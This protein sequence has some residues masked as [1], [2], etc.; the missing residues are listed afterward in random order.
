MSN[1]SEL[2]SEQRVRA[3]VPEGQ[4]IETYS[5]KK[6]FISAP[7]V[8]G[9]QVVLMGIGD[10]WHQM[11][12][13]AVTHPTVVAFEQQHRPSAPQDACDPVITD[14]Y[15]DT[16]GLDMPTCSECARPESDHLKRTQTDTAPQDESL[17]IVRINDEPWSEEKMEAFKPVAPSIGKGQ[18]NQYGI[19]PAEWDAVVKIGCSLHDALMAEPDG[20]D[21]YDGQSLKIMEHLVRAWNAA[22]ESKPEGESKV[23]W[24][25][26]QFVGNEGSGEWQKVVSHYHRDRVEKYM[27]G[28]R[29]TMRLVKIE[30]RETVVETR[31]KEA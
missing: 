9:T 15:F 18:L 11:W 26:E 30:T 25:V 27:Q 24:K 17:R 3:A 1:E 7:L 13:S 10:E 6:L 5:G 21:H 8:V 4:A 12:D 31:K 20:E 19:T 29:F 2:T 16:M 14:H 23:T 22:L 28:S